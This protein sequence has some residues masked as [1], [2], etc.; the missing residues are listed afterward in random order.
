MF[1][2][3]SLSIKTMLMYNMR[4][5][6]NGFSDGNAEGLVGETLRIEE[7]SSEVV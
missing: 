4:L 3:T 7:E 6:T 1:Y 5:T 2:P